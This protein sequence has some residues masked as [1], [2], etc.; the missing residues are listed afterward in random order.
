MLADNCTSSSCPINFHYLNN[1]CLDDCPTGYYSD[2]S[3]LCQTCA[4]GCFSCFGAANTECNKCK[5]DGNE[6]FL[7]D[8]HTCTQTCDQGYYGNTTTHLCVACSAAC[9]TCTAPETCQSCQSVNGVGYFKN[10]T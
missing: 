1:D 8:V 7:K 4:T 2:A 9:Q 3:R 10:G 5:L 6:Y